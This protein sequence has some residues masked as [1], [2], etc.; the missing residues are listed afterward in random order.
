MFFD[1]IKLEGYSVCVRERERE[2]S[3]K[4]YLEVRRGCGVD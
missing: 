1:V 4:I 2:D 3:I